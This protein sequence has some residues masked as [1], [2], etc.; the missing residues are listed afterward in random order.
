LHAALDYVT[1]LLGVADRAAV[2]EVALAGLAGLVGASAATIRH[3]D[4]RR[5]HGG[6]DNRGYDHQM[7]LVVPAGGARAQAVVVGRDGRSFTDRDRRLVALVRGH[8]AAALRR[9]SGGD[10]L[11][12]PGGPPPPLSPLSRREEQVLGLVAEGL[13]DAQ[14]ARRL[15]LSARTVSKHLQRCYRK[16]GV[17]NRVSAV[18]HTPA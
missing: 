4:L 9:A 17:S 14:V 1:K 11:A 15:G 12:P 16:L 6:R 5:G 2:R 8:L 13:T 3:A 7:V 18:R 10:G